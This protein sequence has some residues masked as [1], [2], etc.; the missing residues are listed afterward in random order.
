MQREKLLRPVWAEINLDYL[1]H[2]LLEV[3]RLINK[4]T[5][6]CCVIKADGYGHG[7]LE[8]AK[9]LIEN[10]SDYFA[11]ATLTEAIQLRK[12]GINLPI[13]VLGYTPDEYWQEI[14]QYDITQTIYSLQQAKEFS[15]A[16][17]RVE[18]TMKVHLKVDTGMARLGFQVTEG[19]I[20]DIQSIYHLSNI[21]IEGIYTHLAT[22]DEGDKTYAR[23][24]FSKF[25]GLLETLENSGCSF[26]IR[27]VSN[28]ATIID[29]PEMNLD[30]VRAG[31]MLYG[32]YPSDEV[33][34]EQV[35]LKQV[36][37]V[38]AKVAQVKKLQKGCGVSYGQIYKAEEERQIVTLPIGYADGFTRLLTN[39][40]EVLL[41][42][43]KIPIVGRICMDQ[44]MADATG[45]DVMRGD[46]VII[47]S[48]D[49][50]QGNTVD[51]F[52][53]KLGTINY[54]IIC[55][56]GKRMPRIYMENNNL[57]HVKDSL[58]E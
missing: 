6:V 48:N 24:Q 34:H 10:G 41:K 46:E 57:L 3:K 23:E 42:D 4:G 32:L 2:N 13:L 22:A 12:G 39:K 36:L 18:K 43:K 55:M 9:T 7:A 45:L 29:L 16:A 52:A 17:K 56:I 11:V 14:L 27:H 53:K 20:S 5:K 49:I 21:M 58:V 35:K 50:A 8:I 15:A 25:M 1:K 33:C 28:S 38:K 40:A 37:T 44:C 26:P 54:E 30:M 47:I 19:T 51:D 31:I